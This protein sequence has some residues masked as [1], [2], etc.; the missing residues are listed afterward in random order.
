VG[1]YEQKIDGT[2]QPSISTLMN[3]PIELYLPP[4]STSVKAEF[5]YSPGQS[6]QP[7]LVLVVDGD[8]GNDNYMNVEISDIE[9]SKL[10]DGSGPNSGMFWIAGSLVLLISLMGSA[11]YIIRKP[12]SGSYY[13]EE[14][15]EDWD[16]DNDEEYE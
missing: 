15:D 10:S 1:L 11:F 13:D 4:G 12:G 5:E 7:L 2:F 8:Y 9:V 6:G 16:D 14:N 3:G